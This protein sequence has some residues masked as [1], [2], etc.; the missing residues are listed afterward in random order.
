MIAMGFLSFLA[1]W[2][3]NWWLAVLAP[4]GFA[5]FGYRNL[6]NESTHKALGAFVC[7][8]AFALIFLPMTWSSQRHQEAKYS[9]DV[10]QDVPTA[11]GLS[12]PTPLIGSEEAVWLE[13]STTRQKAIVHRDGDSIVLARR[14]S[15]RVPRAALPALLEGAV[16]TK[17]I[18]DNKFGGATGC[19]QAVETRC[20]WADHGTVGVVIRPVTSTIQETAQILDQMRNFIEIPSNRYHPFGDAF[21]FIF[22][23]I[24]LGFL[25]ALSIVGHEFAHAA[26]AL[27][28]GN[29]VLTICI[30]MGRTLVDRKFGSVQLLLKAMPIGGYIQSVAHKDNG[31]RERQMIVWAAGP[32]ANMIMAI[33]FALFV[34]IGH[35]LVLANVG[36][37]V[38][39]LIP[40]SKEIPELGRRIGTDG[41]QLMEF[42]LGRR[43]FGNGFKSPKPD[44]TDPTDTRRG[45]LRFIAA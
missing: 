30:G 8:I 44:P 27:A 16:P 2:I 14:Q 45:W 31:Y 26:A 19:I 9:V 13:D 34:G 6:R 12:A 32:L 36:L 5:F 23:L 39:N 28:V 21:K 40:F 29:E 3:A 20:A 42:A 17:I 18:T 38:V 22:Y 15:N 7:A 1:A 35:P 4:I 11:D 24:L 43:E 37:F 25:L 10:R 41:F 33:G